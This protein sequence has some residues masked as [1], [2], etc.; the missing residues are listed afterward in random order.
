[1]CVVPVLAT[2]FECLVGSNEEDKGKAI[3][4]VLLTDMCHARVYAPSINGVIHLRAIGCNIM[5]CGLGNLVS[6][7]E[8]TRHVVVGF[9]ELVVC[10]EAAERVIK[11]V[12]GL[13]D[14][15][16]VIIEHVLVLVQTIC[17]TNH[18]LRLLI[19]ARG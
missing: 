9:A 11:R 8:V 2:G 4:L 7:T 6:K 10:E 12:N 16:G 18:L 14:R 17:K 1:M 5:L 13:L 15:C 19:M 3:I